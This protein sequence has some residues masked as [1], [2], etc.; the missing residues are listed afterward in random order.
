QLSCASISAAGS[1]W[2]ETPLWPTIAR[3]PASTIASGR[4]VLAPAALTAPSAG[5]TPTC[6]SVTI[7]L[8]SLSGSSRT[9][10]AV[11]TASNTR[12][13]AAT[14][15]GRLS[16]G[17]TEKYPSPRLSTTDRP[18]LEY[19]TSMELLVLSVTMEPSSSSTVD[20]PPTVV[21]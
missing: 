4:T 3:L 2:M 12:P 7:I 6:P 16:S 13:P 10:N 17:S 5:N 20:C 9:L 1:A 8:M 15:N 14:L 19:R 11:P 18:V 21:S